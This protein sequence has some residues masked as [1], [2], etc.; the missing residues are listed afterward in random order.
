MKAE[1]MSGRGRVGKSG[2][3]LQPDAAPGRWE[4]PG[5]A[6]TATCSGPGGSHMEVAE[7]KA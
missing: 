3:W 7:G 1:A 5:T 4:P 2:V 6:H